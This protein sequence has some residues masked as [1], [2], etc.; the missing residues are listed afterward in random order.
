L[1]GRALNKISREIKSLFAESDKNFLPWVFYWVAAGLFVI[2]I[3]VN[4][5][6]TRGLAYGVSSVLVGSSIM[7]AI[8]AVIVVVIRSNRER[9]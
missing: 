3:A 4:E 5:A 1:G 9:S 6:V 7:V 2:G 8:A